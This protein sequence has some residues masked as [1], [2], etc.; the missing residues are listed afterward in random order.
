M[1]VLLLKDKSV[2]TLL[3]LDSRIIPL[4]VLTEIQVVVLVPYFSQIKHQPPKKLV[5]K[6]IISLLTN[7]LNKVYMAVVKLPR[8]S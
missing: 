3:L 5:S 2:V 6:P 7:A 8:L 4:V 1:E